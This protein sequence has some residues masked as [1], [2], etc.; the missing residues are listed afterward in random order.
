MKQHNPQDVVLKI[1]Q[2]VEKLEFTD[3][4]IQDYAQEFNISES[5][6]RKMAKRITNELKHDLDQV[7]S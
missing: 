2:F 1:K 4:E 5:T 3:A 7:L 6:M